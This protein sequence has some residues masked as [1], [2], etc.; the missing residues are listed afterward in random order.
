MV[1]SCDP[2]LQVASPQWGE[3]TGQ[4]IARDGGGGKGRPDWPVCSMRGGSG[5]SSGPTS[6]P[7]RESSAATGGLYVKGRPMA[8]G[9]IATAAAREFRISD[10]ESA[11]DQARVP[12]RITRPGFHPVI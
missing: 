4:N 10:I 3:A 8:L 7:R 5:T 12:A 9:R 11:L 6:L 1:L 2:V